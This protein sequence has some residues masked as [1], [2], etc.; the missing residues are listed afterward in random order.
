M[1]MYFHAQWPSLAGTTSTL[2]EQAIR[3]WSTPLPSITVQ[4]SS[5]S[6]ILWPTFASP[7]VR[8]GSE[9]S[10]VSTLKPLW[11]VPGFLTIS[12]GATQGLFAFFHT[13]LNPGDEVIIME[14][15]YDSYVPQVKA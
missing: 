3:D 10:L 8:A 12:A 11:A 5:N 6:W 7:L 1:F 9:A 2:A 4:Y 15:F 14:P 13:F